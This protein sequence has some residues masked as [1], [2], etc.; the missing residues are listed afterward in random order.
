MDL[1]TPSI[2]MLLSVMLST[3]EPHYAAELQDKT[4]LSKPTVSKGLATFKSAGIVEVW[5]ENLGFSAKRARRKHYDLT[6]SFLDTYRL[7]PSSCRSS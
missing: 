1:S 6:N 4:G 2:R 5:D 7:T 3:D